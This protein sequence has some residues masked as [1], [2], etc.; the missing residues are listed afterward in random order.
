MPSAMMPCPDCGY[1]MTAFEKNCPR[2]ERLGERLK[3]CLKCGTSGG[4]GDILCRRCGHR[5]GD[6]VEHFSATPP[7]KAPPAQAA[8]TAAPTAAPDSVDVPRPMDVD[9]GP[10][11]HS[12]GDVSA[13]DPVQSPRR[14]LSS[15]A[16]VGFILSGLIATFMLVAVTS[17][18]VSSQAEAAKQAQVEQNKEDGLR[19]CVA[20]DTEGCHYSMDRLRDAG[21][22]DDAEFLK[23]HLIVSVALDESQSTYRANGGATSAEY[24]SDAK[25]ISDRAFLL[26]FHGDPDY[27]FYSSAEDAAKFLADYG[28]AHGLSGRY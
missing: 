21:Q 24:D 11:G 25:E 4:A 12:P 28:R 6:P 19:Q 18:V 27:H 9:I 8:S 13:T 20:G 10:D 5:F 26:A 7:G 16:I 15:A 17:S 23:A 3:P 2:C 14:R 22:P 1:M